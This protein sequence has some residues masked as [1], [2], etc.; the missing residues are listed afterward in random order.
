MLLKFR[1]LMPYETADPKPKVL[2]SNIYLASTFC[3]DPLCITENPFTLGIPSPDPLVTQVISPNSRDES[4]PRMQQ[5]FPGNSS[6]PDTGRRQ[7]SDHV[8]SRRPR[9]PSPPPDYPS[10]PA[11]S[12]DGDCRSIDSRLSE[13]SEV[14]SVVCVSLVKLHYP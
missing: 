11:S 5:P 13:L 10:S 3:D 9:P 6:R 2:S 7:L 8:I 14:S 4:S 12:I 1:Y